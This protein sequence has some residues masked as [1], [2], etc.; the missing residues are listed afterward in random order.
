MATQKEIARLAGVSVSS[1]SAVLNGTTHTRMSHATRERIEAAIAEAGY[2]PNDAARALR[3]QQAGTIAVVVEKLENPAYKELFHGIYEAAEERGWAVVLGDVVWMR[4]GS[5][6]LARLLGRGSIDA[7]VLRQDRLIDEEVLAH[8]RARPTPVVLV[9]RQADPHD[10]WIAVDDLAA[11][12]MAAEH[13]IEL[14]HRDIAFVGGEGQPSAARC[15]GYATAM[16]S[17]G[18]VSS[19]PVVTG[20]GPESGARGLDELRARG[21]LPTAVVVANVMSAVGLLAA[22]ADAG[23]DV[24]G[25][26]SV[27]GIHDADIADVVRPSLTTVKLPMRA[28]GVRAVEQVSALL[29]GTPTELGV[30]TDPPPEVIVRSSTAPPE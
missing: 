1:V 10:S 28:L 23:I 29:A 4:S 6:F 5:H 3:R 15:E 7:I 24:P 9:E 12:R 22:A 26:F 17:A 25:R 16:R 11:G 2:V 8:L 18:L 21:V 14:G 27:V 13:L 30:F 20:F 19:S